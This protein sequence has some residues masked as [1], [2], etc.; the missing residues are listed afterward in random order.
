MTTWIVRYMTTI[1]QVVDITDDDDEVLI[2]ECIKLH[3]A[4]RI[5]E[6]H[7]LFQEYAASMVSNYANDA[8]ARRVLAR[9]DNEMER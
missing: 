9:L 2:A 6:L 4:E 1:T 7:S 5:V 3:D 8:A